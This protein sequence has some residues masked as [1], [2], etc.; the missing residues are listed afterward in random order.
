VGAR[1]AVSPLGR[2]LVAWRE[3]GRIVTAGGNL[4]AG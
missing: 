3:G 4:A 2:T 1:L